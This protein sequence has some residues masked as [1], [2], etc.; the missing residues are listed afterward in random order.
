MRAEVSK[1]PSWRKCV[2]WAV[3]FFIVSLVLLLFALRLFVQT[4][5]GARWIETQVNSRSFGPLERVEISGLSGDPLGALSVRSV[6]VFDKEGLWLTANGIDVDWNP[7]ALRHKSVDFKS[8]TLKTSELLRRP[9]LNEMPAPEPNALSVGLE[10]FD[11]QTFKLNE[12]VLGESA[13]FTLGGGLQRRKNSAIQA[14][15][16]ALRTDSAGDSLNLD[17]TK[18]ASG[19]MTGDFDL[20]GKAGGTISTLLKS[21]TGAQITGEGSLE[22]RLDSGQARLAIRFDDAPK[23]DLNG[24]WTEAAATVTA[25]VNTEDWNLFDAARSGLGSRVNVTAGLDRTLT[26]AG[27]DVGVLSTRLKANVAGRLSS[28]G[29][30]PNA[31]NLTASSDNLGAI[32]PLPERFNLGK[33]EIKG[34]ADIKPAYKF[35][36][37]VR[38]NDVLSPYGS[39]A[40]VRG[41]LDITQ[42]ASERYKFT[43]DLTAQNLRLEMESPIALSPTT[44]LQADGVLSTKT[45][46]ISELS[47]VFVSGENRISVNGK[48]NY[49]VM[50][51]DISGTAAVDVLPIG[52]VPAGQLQTDYG[53][54]KTVSSELTISANGAF[55][56]SG[57]MSAPLGPLIAGGVNFDIDMTPIEGGI[58]INNA[59]ATGEN[60]RAIIAGTVTDSLDLTGE[61]LLSAPL[62]YPPLALSGETA[63]SFTVTGARTN[64]SV[65]LDAQA[66]EVVMSGYALTGARLRAELDDIVRAPTG[67]LRLTA[68]TQQGPLDVS[69]NFESR[70]QLYV[71]ND[72]DLKLGRM[73]AS[74]KLS[75]GANTPAMGELTLNL[76]EEGDQYARAK[77]KLSAKGAEQGLSIDVDAKN[78]AYKT[79]AFDSLT[80]NAEGTLGGLTGELEAKGQ[81]QLAILERQFS[82]KAP[83][84]AAQTETGA[85]EASL[86]PEA[87]YGNVSLETK[88]PISARYNSGDV[89]VVAPLILAGTPFDVSYNRV[90]QAETLAIKTTGL[91]ISIIPM[92][93]NLADTRGRFGI[94][95][96]VETSNAG[97]GVVGGGTVNLVDWRGFDVKPESGL[98]GDMV[99]DLSGNTIGWQLKVLSAGGFAANSDGQIPLLQGSSITDL[100]PNM[101]APLS[102]QFSASGQ[103]AAVLGL[104][105]PSDAKP[106]GELSANVR[107]TGTAANPLMEGKIDGRALRM[108]APALGTQLRDGRFTANFTNDTLRVSDVSISD[109]GKGTMTGQGEFKLGEFGR[110][111]GDLKMVASQFRALNRKD[112]EGTVSGALGLNSTQDK[113]TVTGA[114]K[115]N[116]AEVKQFVS[117]S[118]SV[119]EIPVVEINKPKDQKRVLTKAPAKPLYLDVKLRAPRRIFVRSR[120]L[121]V[122]LSVDAS[123]KGTLQQPEIFGDATVL[124][125]GY[126]IAGKTLQFEDGGIRFFGPLGDARVNLIANTDTQNLSASVKITG[127]VAKPEIELSSTPD[128]PQ[129]EI[130][131]ALLFGRSATELSTI[132]AAQLAGALAQFSGAGGGFDLMGGLRD[133]LG[134]GQLSIGLG[135]DGSAQI[136]GGRYLAKNVYLQ[137][138]SGGGSGKTGAVI[139]WEVRRNISLTS[140]IQADNDQSFALRWKR[141]F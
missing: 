51:Y 65:R 15:L 138:F 99:L 11:V 10:R 8:I 55:K 56:P 79:F 78:I 32:L 57:D 111:V 92:P 103:A 137:V 40:N 125:G 114:I 49:G 107:V 64:P 67:P 7:W 66:S 124:R 38:L 20:M 72:I 83:F 14:K 62:F 35:V 95:M 123:I 60:I 19:E 96:K 86:N 30:L 82:L 25:A 109:N 110:P 140:K 58:K 73:S 2:L 44:T 75:K 43:G 28:D 12:A 116:R 101:N 129:D 21:P 42:M 68:E 61:G 53:V 106:S 50:S 132:E 141:D 134:V 136:S 126:K 52:A 29:G 90:G 47:A 69:A 98:S 41:P 130:L 24:N 80:A 104:F 71:A 76:P 5:S 45:S 84:N 122:E 26:P 112:F 117:G 39:V 133:A 6:K 88:T 17:F 81:R 85:F 70:D 135:E 120:G 3:L 121:D 131:S 87:K 63:A 59:M 100:R 108:E 77:L 93:G 115:L 54:R 48:A 23:I 105:T 9:V 13:V 94:D 139:D 16:N 89:A 33:G 102:G 22:G 31:I 34:R 4:N 46:E 128:R 37:D 74:G 91:P 36:G 113:A 118:A 27:F 1:K 119:V 127:T 97:T 18:S